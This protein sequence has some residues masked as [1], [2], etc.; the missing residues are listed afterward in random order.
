M[1]SCKEFTLI[2]RNKNQI[3]RRKFFYEIIDP[4]PKTVVIFCRYKS[5][6]FSRRVFLVTDD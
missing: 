1:D 2:Y 5:V 3:Y 6:L 4:A